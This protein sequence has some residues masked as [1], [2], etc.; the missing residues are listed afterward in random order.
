MA[1]APTPCP[2]WDVAALVGHVYSDVPR[3][4]VA[5]RGE[6]PD[7]SG[8]RTDQIGDDWAG[9]FRTAGATLLETWRATD[10]TRTV[11]MP[12]GGEQ[13]LVKLADQ[14]TAEFAIHAWDIARA[15]D[16][17][18]EL[19]PAVGQRA[20][21]F[22]RQNLRPEHRGDPGS[23]FAREV[24]VPEDAPIYDRVAAWFGRDPSW[25]PHR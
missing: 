11:P 3:F 12:G 2:G 6:R 1:T 23:A 22:G 4:T 21:D 15:T 14:Q 5:A 24:S 7:W 10:P 8:P 25:S 18:I 17:S 9:D 19:D 16:Q 13:P 20:L